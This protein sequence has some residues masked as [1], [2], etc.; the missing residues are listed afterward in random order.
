MKLSSGQRAIIRSSQFAVPAKRWG[1]LVDIAHCQNAIAR[2]AQP[3]ATANLTLEE[4]RSGRKRAYAALAKFILKG[5][6]WPR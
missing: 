2:L 6:K 1:P 5:G 4:I 3:W